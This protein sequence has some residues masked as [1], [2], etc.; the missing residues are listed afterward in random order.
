MK[1]FS[2]GDLQTTTISLETMHL[3]Y[4]VDLMRKSKALSKEKNSGWSLM[5]MTRCATSSILHGF[6]ALESSVNFIGYE[7]FF[8]KKSNRFIPVDKRDY[9]LNKFLKTW[10]KSNALEKLEFILSHSNTPLPAKLHNELREL[11]NLRNWIAHGFVY[12]TT[13]LLDPNNDEHEQS[14]IV[15][16]K[17]DDVDWKKKFP[18]TKFNALAE[19][20]YDDAQIALT[21]VLQVLKIFSE[22]FSRPYTLITCEGTANFKILW[23]DSFDIQEIVKSEFNQK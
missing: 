16:D 5:R 4:S 8:Y 23:K 15:V 21:I 19:L 10:D 9:L 1:K 17:E 6:C 7:M 14:Y 3:G 18:N 2:S 22:T 13:F 20:N 11:N 12:Q